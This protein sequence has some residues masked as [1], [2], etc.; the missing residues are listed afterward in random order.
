MAPFTSTNAATA[1]SLLADA[2]VERENELEVQLSQ[3]LQEDTDE[4]NGSECPIMDTFYGQG[5][6]EGIREMTNFSPMEFERVWEAFKV[7]IMSEYNV[8]RGRKCDVVQYPA[9]Q[10]GEKERK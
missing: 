6:A 9:L 4:E 8:G 7:H 5:G 10:G 2:A 1:L 3:P